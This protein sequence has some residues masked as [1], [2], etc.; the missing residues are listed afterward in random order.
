MLF[1][2]MHTMRRDVILTGSLIPGKMASLIQFS[3]LHCFT[4]IQSLTPLSDHQTTRVMYRS[5]EE[6][7]RL[8]S[9]QRLCQAEM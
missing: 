9:Y 4:T 8:P 3:S 5:K 6:L 7:S 1:T 2:K